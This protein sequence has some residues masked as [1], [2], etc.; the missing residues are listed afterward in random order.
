MHPHYL[1]H[2]LPGAAIQIQPQ[3]VDFLDVRTFLILLS[4]T[5]V[6]TGRSALLCRCHVFDETKSNNKQAT[7]TSF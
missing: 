3:A 5:T 6:I 2:R 4:A 7:A 1:Y